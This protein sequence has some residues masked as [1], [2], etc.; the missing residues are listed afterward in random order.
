LIPVRTER[1]AGV[2]AIGSADPERFVP[3]T[4]VDFLTRLGELVS[5]KLQSVAQEVG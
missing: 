3:D 5:L 1:L 4:G 2:L